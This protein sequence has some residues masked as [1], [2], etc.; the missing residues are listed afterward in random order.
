VINDLFERIMASSRVNQPDPSHA[1]TPAMPFWEKAVGVVGL[2]LVLGILGFFIY[3]GFQPDTPPEIVIEIEQIVA[4]GGGYLVQFHALNR[5]SATAAGVL[6]EGTLSEAA[7]PTGEPVATSQVTFDYIPA[8]S[9]RQGGLFFQAN[10]EQYQL[11][12]QVKGYLE[13]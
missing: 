7:N 12:I 9:T 11:Q 10:P 6:V 4:N 1:Q 13:P 8:Y 5:G 3:Q 2:F